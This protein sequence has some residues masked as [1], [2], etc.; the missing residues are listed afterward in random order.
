MEG[1][2]SF[3]MQKQLIIGLDTSCYT[4]SLALIDGTGAVALDRRILLRVK[5][6]ERGLRQ[7]EAVFQ[8][9]QNLPKLLETP[10][11]E[12]AIALV[13]M[14]V[15]PRP[16]EGA[17][18]PVFQAGASF[19]ETLAKLV[20]APWIG[21]SHQ[22]GHIRAGLHHAAAVWNEAFLAWHISGGTTELLLVR[23]AAVGYALDLLGG[24]SDLQVGQFVD[25]I[26]V[27]LGAAFP[28]GPALERLALLAAAPEPL[29]VVTRDL[30]ISFSGPL[31]AAERKLA[32]GNCVPENLALGV[33]QAIAAALLQVT[34][35]AALRHGIRRV[36]LVGGVASN[37]II[38]DVLS[39][40]GTRD[41]IDFQFGAKELSSDNAVG[42]GLLGYDYLMDAERRI[43]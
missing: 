4:T 41:G 32:A 37:Q 43:S 40:A 21:L 13:A 31:S 2:P 16:V 34:Q 9:L 19:G 35:R 24:S 12:P 7:S 6:G 14:S 1:V 3:F 22:E 17:Y 20:G 38:R 39:A 28:A 23:P 10:L 36:L 11:E 29:P 27:A 8:H 5:P 33:F 25:R 30:T 26:G 15:R 18:L 42:I